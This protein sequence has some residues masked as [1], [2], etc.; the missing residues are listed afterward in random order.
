MVLGQKLASSMQRPAMPLLESAV[1]AQALLDLT[2]DAVIVADSLGQLRAWNATAESLTGFSGR[3][4]SDL[5]LVQ[6]LPDLPPG[7]ATPGAA[8][9]DRRRRIWSGPLSLLRPDGVSL[10]VDVRC[11]M[12]S[13]GAQ[14]LQVAVLSPSV[15]DWGLPS[16]AA[17]RT[18]L[19]AMKLA[20]DARKQRVAFLFIDIDRFRS[21]NDAIGHSA[22]NQVLQQVSTA[23]AA[24]VGDSGLLTHL[25]GNEFLAV[26]SGIESMGQVSD[27]VE[28]IR[29]ALN[30]DLVSHGHVFR[31]SASVGI[32]LYPDD[33]VDFE[34]LVRQADVAKQLSRRGGRN[35]VLFHT[36]RMNV[37]LERRRN[38]ERAL[39][40]AVDNHELFMRYQPQIDLQ[41]GRIIGLEALVRWAR[42]GHGEIAP[43]DFI[44]VAEESGLI[45][46]LGPETFRMVVAQL[47]TWHDAGIA[48]PVSVNLSTVEIAHGDADTRILEIIESS[49]IPPQLLSIEITESGL[50]DDSA[51]TEITIANLRESGV[52]LSI[53]DF[54]TGDS[55]FAYLRRFQASHLKIDRSFVAGIDE[56]HDNQSIV[57][58]AVEMASVLGIATIAEGTETRAEADMVRDLGC[59]AAQGYFFSR[60]LLASEV[61]I[62]LRR[63]T[64]ELDAAPPN[65]ENA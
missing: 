59:S 31:L 16:A 24:V 60:P 57:R 61:E 18:R 47:C 65:K 13:D 40:A 42:P 3:Q 43:A 30:Q 63:G 39:S 49:G 15:V 27:F 56:R 62:L 52:G 41:T 26:L 11:T 45:V 4:M 1:L 14:R 12:V 17:V 10:A 35:S 48:V 22:G 21:V 53:D 37:D 34:V 28:R 9:E 20:A 8:L 29:G 25:A 44:P 50:I 6:L 33:G 2:S 46:D 36:D 54:L 19:D 64:T 51:K 55:N 58:A 23:L 38:M 7:L 5:L 32:A